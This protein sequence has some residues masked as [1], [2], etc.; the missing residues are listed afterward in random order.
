[1]KEV[2]EPEWPDPPLADYPEESYMDTRNNQ[3]LSKL[4]TLPTVELPPKKTT[5][6]TD[7]PSSGGG[8]G[9]FP[10]TKTCKPPEKKISPPVQPKMAMA[11][12]DKLQEYNQEFKQWQLRLVGQVLDNKEMIK[13][14][15]T[16]LQSK[17]LVV[18]LKDGYKFKEIKTLEKWQKAAEMA[19]AKFEKK[20]G[21]ESTAKK[22]KLVRLLLQ[23]LKEVTVWNQM[24]QLF[25][26]DRKKIIEEL[27]IKFLE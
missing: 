3:K 15:V 16:G 18:L 7:P 23:K 17:I 12:L 2:L 21:Q 11:G 26:L 19:V 22:L 9:Y 6:I 20:A 25:K 8:G 13:A 4:P 27:A 1:M 24:K 5:K 14:F 10:Q